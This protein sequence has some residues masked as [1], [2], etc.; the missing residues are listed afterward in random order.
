[1]SC[2]CEQD[3]KVVIEGLTLQ[4]AH[5]QAI[6][7]KTCKLCREEPPYTDNEECFECV[8]FMIKKALQGAT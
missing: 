7:H 2:R 8:V 3:C 1:M 5:I 6:T 4:L